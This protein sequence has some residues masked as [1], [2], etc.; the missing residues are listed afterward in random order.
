MDTFISRLP[1]ALALI[2]IGAAAYAVYSRWVIRRAGSRRLG[3]EQARAGVP[4][5]LYFTTPSCVPCRTVQ[6]PALDRLSARFEQ[7]LQI[8][9]IDAQAQPEIADHW[10]VLSVPTTFV[11]D[12]A[13]KTRFFNFGVTPAEKLQHQLAQVGLSQNG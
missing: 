7:A 3:L 11:I 13:G 12:S 10:G 5:I 6:A 2:I 8:V 4:T 1:I 9:K